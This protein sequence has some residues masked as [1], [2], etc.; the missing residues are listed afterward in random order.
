MPLLEESLLSDS[1][2]S[3]SVDCEA[4]SGPPIRPLRDSSISTRACFLLSCLCVL[5]RAGAFA[6]FATFA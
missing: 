4:G 3:I 6:N 2:A 1:G 5:G